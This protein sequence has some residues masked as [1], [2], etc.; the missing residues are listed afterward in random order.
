M[1]LLFYCLEQLMNSITYQIIPYSGYKWIFCFQNS[2]TDHYQYTSKAALIKLSFWV[3]WHV[4][5]LMCCRLQELEVYCCY[6]MTDCGLLEGIGSLQKLKSLRLNWGC[7]LTSQA[8]STFLHRPSMNSIQLLEL[9]ICSGLD[10]EGLK[11]IAERCLKLIYLCLNIL[12]CLEH[13]VQ[14]C[15]VSLSLCFYL[16]MH[17]FER[18]DSLWA[19][20][21]NWCWYQ[22]GDNL[23]Q[24]AAHTEFEVY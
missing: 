11:G 6:K 13:E 10:D 12:V 23:L 19:L 21:C 18:I 15:G 2:I 20:W 16:Q 8:L 1:L 4:M 9:S 22:R 14:V 3:R 24:S 5:L 7:S 17:T